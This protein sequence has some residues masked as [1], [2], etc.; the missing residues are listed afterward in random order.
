MPA[1]AP[2]GRGVRAAGGRGL[3]GVPLISSAVVL[4]SSR[5]RWGDSLGSLGSVGDGLW[6]GETLEKGLYRVS[7]DSLWTCGLSEDRVGRGS[8][9]GLRAIITPQE[10]GGR[11]MVLSETQARN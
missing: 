1:P 10:A 4:G 7:T 8:P 11:V 9:S 2:Q 6:Q 5:T 3:P